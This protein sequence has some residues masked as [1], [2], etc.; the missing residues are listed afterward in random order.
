MGEQV[1]QIA[2]LL[3]D[4]SPSDIQ[5]LLEKLSQEVPQVPVAPLVPLFEGFRA[6]GLKLGVATNDAE[7]SMA[8]HLEVAEIDALLDFAVGFDSGFGHKPGPGQLLGFADH[9]GLD[10]RHIFFCVV[11][12]LDLHAARA[13][14]MVGIGVLSGPAEPEVLSPHAEVVLPTIADIPAWLAA[15]GAS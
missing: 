1:E 14:G 5:N 15:R 4:R 6:A 9:L 8:R 2:P 12:N 11:F 3:P 10:P 13:A 7:A